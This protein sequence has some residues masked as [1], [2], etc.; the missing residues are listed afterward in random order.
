MWRLT[1]ANPALGQLRQ[2]H[3]KYQANLG[4]L[5]RLRLCGSLGLCVRA[6]VMRGS[7]LLGYSWLGAGIA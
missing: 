4:S 7:R 3:R 6:C 1:L 5:A 2:E